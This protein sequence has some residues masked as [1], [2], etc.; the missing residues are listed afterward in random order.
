LSTGSSPP[1]R[2]SSFLHGELPSSCRASSSSQCGAGST[3]RLGAWGPNDDYDEEFPEATQ[4]WWGP[5]PLPQRETPKSLPKRPPTGTTPAT[6]HGTSHPPT[7]AV[8]SHPP[9][10]LPVT[11]PNR[12]RSSAPSGR[13]GRWALRTALGRGW[14]RWRGDAR[15]GRQVRTR[16]NN[17]ARH[18]PRSSTRPP[19]PRG[20]VRKGDF[21]TRPLKEKRNDAVRH[22]D[23]EGVVRAICVRA[24]CPRQRSQP[25]RQQ[26]PHVQ[27][28][29][30][31]L[32]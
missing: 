29:L 13:R 30:S 4:P 19:L 17:P 16:N 2:R 3:R 24:P 14:V 23:D 6:T 20:Q 11:L 18:P 32:G 1:Q 27:T 7:L 21:R 31:P 25:I 26:P 12:G 5:T 28:A 15:D 9:S 10:L 8:P 22:T